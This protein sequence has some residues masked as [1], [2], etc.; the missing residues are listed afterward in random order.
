[1]CPI[2]G[3]SLAYEM[4]GVGPPL[5][6]LHGFSFDMRAWDGQIERLARSHRVVRYDLRG[7]G[8]SSLPVGSYSHSDD[9]D[10]L[11]SELG[12]KRPILMGL[13]LGAN[14]VLE[15]SLLHPLMVRAQIL[16]S[17]GLVGHPWREQ[18]PPDAAAAHAA[19]YGV[20]SAKR[21]W[22]EHVLFASL[23]R[24]PAAMARLTLM[25]ADYSGWHWRHPNPVRT[26]RTADR[27]SGCSVATLVLSG[28]LDVGGYR[29]IA[30]KL[31][32]DIDGT[33]LVRFAHAGHVLNDD[34]DPDFT[35]AVLDFTKDHR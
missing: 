13:S 35:T 11:L 30:M 14:V 3:G 23:R 8:R 5:V 2:D 31:S 7:F 15:Y 1:M 16:A 9:L 21:F 17:P 28:D 18:R 22:L 33:K 25:V 34:A 27:L 4:R 19:A 20:E 6:L 26:P 12:V 10:A 32:A 24:H 29:D